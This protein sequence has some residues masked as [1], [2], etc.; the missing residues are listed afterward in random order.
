MLSVGEVMSIGRTWEER[1]TLILLLLLRIYMLYLIV[2]T[3]YVASHLVPR[4]QPLSVLALV[5]T[6]VY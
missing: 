4:L 1:Y 2:T 5:L 6:S 3:L